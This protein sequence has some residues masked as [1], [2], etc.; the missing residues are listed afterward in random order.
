MRSSQSSAS[1]YRFS[2]NSTFSQWHARDSIAST[3]TTWSH[4]SDLSRDHFISQAERSLSAHSSISYPQNVG[5]LE[6]PTPEPPPKRLTQRQPAQD[7]EPF[8]TCVSRAKRPRRGGK[9]PKYWCTSCREGFG[10]KYDWKRHEETFQERSEMYECGL[11]NKSYFLDKDFIHHHQKG[12]RCKTCAENQHVE[13]ARRRRVSRTGWG[14]GFCIRFDSDWAERC[15]HVA[16]HFERGDTMANWKH[17]KLIFSLLQQPIIRDAWIH[18]I[19]EKQEL[20]P[21]FGWNQSETGRAEGYPDSNR[22]PQLQDL[23]EFY[24]PDQSAETLVQLA[25]E[26]GHRRQH[27]TTQN[28]ELMHWLPGANAEANLHHDPPARS[29]H[30]DYPSSLPQHPTTLR[31]NVPSRSSSVHPPRLEKEL[32]SLPS[33]SHIPSIG[34]DHIHSASKIQAST[35]DFDH[36]GKLTNTIPEDHVLPDADPMAFGNFNLHFTHGYHLQ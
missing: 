5:P 13:N 4:F 17:A 33:D 23:L 21:S 32:P 3:N 10:E 9:E 6:E 29:V 8:S 34:H 28:P 15:K 22:P 36:W 30:I 2:N 31:P 35:I 18:L 24:T 16:W 20:N 25:Y 1:N 7:K 26:K 14:C 19:E 11:C 12:H 27:K